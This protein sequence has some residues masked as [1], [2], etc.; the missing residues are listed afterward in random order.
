M[1]PVTAIFFSCRRIEILKRTI[2]AFEKFNTYPLED[3]LIVNDSGDE[4]IN[5]HNYYATKAKYD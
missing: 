2:A 3:L 4:N 5:R 1:E